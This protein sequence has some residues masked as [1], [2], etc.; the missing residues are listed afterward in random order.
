MLALGIR[1]VLISGH[2]NIAQASF[3][4]FGAYASGA[5]AMKL[6]WSF[7][8]CLPLAGVIA[9]ILAIIV[10]LP[11]LRIKGAY[12]VIITLGLSEVSRRIWMMWDSLFGGP[13]GL[14]GIPLPDPIKLG[15]FAIMFNSKV[16]YFYL[17]FVLFVITVFVMWRFEKSRTGLLLKSFPQ[18]D[19]LAE[20]S[21]VYI[22]KYK[23]AA[24]ALGA[25][26]AGLAGSFW[27]HY[28]TYCSPWDF[29]LMAS[30]YMLMYVVMGGTG[31]IAGP[32][33]GSAVMLTLDELL[34][35]FKEYMPMILGVILILVL[36]FM[37]GGIIS[38]PGLIRDAFMRK[39]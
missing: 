17:A 31:S 10:G 25:F 19:M 16:H 3:M 39:E 12:F 23:V 37:P 18:A 24:F 35:P 27:A 8:I 36:R 32:I 22:M 26:F 30:F 38:I 29:T 5:L 13:Q 1:I 28:F 4:G 20:S 2:L 14:L 6:G 34:R 21:G 9:A 33:V 15:S 11:T 7:W